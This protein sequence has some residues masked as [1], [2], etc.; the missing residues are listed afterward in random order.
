MTRIVIPSI[1]MRHMHLEPNFF[2][3]NYAF[4]FPADVSTEER[5]DMLEL[6]SLRERVLEIA[7]KYGMLDS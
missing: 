3:K 2:N 5:K 1:P 7:T 6:H 4:M